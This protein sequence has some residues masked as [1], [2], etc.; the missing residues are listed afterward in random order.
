MRAWHR[1][2]RRFLLLLLL[3]LLGGAAGVGTWVASVSLYQWMMIG[4]EFAVADVIIIGSRL[5]HRDEVLAISGLTKG[6]NIFKTNL[7]EAVR[8]LKRDPRVQDAFLRRQFPNRI[9]VH[10][11]EKRP[12]AIINLDRLY[13][14][15]ANADLIPL[16]ASERLPNLPIITGFRLAGPGATAVDGAR[17]RQE[18][19]RTPAVRRALD[20][21]EAI[22]AV[23]PGLLDEISEVHVEDPD[24]PILYTVQGGVEVR[25]G[26]GRYREKLMRLTLMF[27]RLKQ[28]G[29]TT[30]S[31]DLRFDKLAIIRPLVTERPDDKRS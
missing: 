15:D 7:P 20:I 23:S 3:L 17:V 5:I 13:G 8:Q 28:D 27:Q 12:I 31:I 25:I 24:D 6:V 1:K 19:A 2:W 22:R 26:V 29:I 10:L 21:I 11:V 9:V 18:A 14:I 16:P 30:A 4:R